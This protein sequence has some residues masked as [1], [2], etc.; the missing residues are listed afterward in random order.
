MDRRVPH[1][2]QISDQPLACGHYQVTCPEGCNLGTSAH[3]A[4]QAAA[5]RRVALHAAATRQFG[6][7]AADSKDGQ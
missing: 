5:D 1:I 6:F 7:L 3:A 2:A 4:D